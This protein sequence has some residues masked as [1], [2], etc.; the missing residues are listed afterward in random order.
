MRL[1]RTLP[2]WATK[3]RRIKNVP[4][5]RQVVLPQFQG[6]KRSQ[7]SSRLN[8]VTP[9]KAILFKP[10]RGHTLFS[11]RYSPTDLFLIAFLVM[12]YIYIYIYIY[13]F[14]LFFVNQLLSMGVYFY[15]K[16][17]ECYIKVSCPHI[18]LNVDISVSEDTLILQVSTTFC[19]AERSDSSSDNAIRLRAKKI[20][21]MPAILL[22]LILQKIT[23]AKAA[24]AKL[25][26]LLLGTKVVL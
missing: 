8:G 2:T 16:F 6:S 11:K 13:Y 3:V 7:I 12:S 5:F 22:F 21:H 18:I 17:V 23:S 9:Q 24:F 4:T 15:V 26:K 1:T 10:Q 25:C 20:F 14:G 19:M